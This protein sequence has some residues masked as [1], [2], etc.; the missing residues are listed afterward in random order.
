MKKQ[1]TNISVDNYEILLQSAVSN[2]GNFEHHYG[3]EKEMN[4]VFS[5]DSNE[6]EVDAFL[7]GISNESLEGVRIKEEQVKVK[8]DEM[9]KD[10]YD[11]MLKVFGTSNDVSAQATAST[12][13]AMA[14][15][16]AN[17]VG[18]LGLVD[19]AAVLAYA[20]VEIAKADTY[21]VFRLNRIAQFNSEKDAILNS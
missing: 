6:A 19:E 17:Y 18:Q 2:F 13:E 8:Y 16:P 5:D 12:Y 9:V 7:S 21:A 15:R 3:N 10:V 14:K 20:N 4:L 1:L 11:E